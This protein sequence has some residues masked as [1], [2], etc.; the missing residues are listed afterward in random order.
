M[1]QMYRSGPGGYAT[2][3]DLEAYMRAGGMSGPVYGPAKRP[4]YNT[5]Q[6][7]NLRFRRRKRRRGRRGCVTPA[8]K[9]FN[10]FAWAGSA[11]TTSWTGQGHTGGE[12]LV[13][14]AQ[15]VTESTRVGRKVCVHDINIKGRVSMAAGTTVT[16][17]HNQVHLQLILDNQCN[18]ANATMADIY[19]TVASGIDSYRNLANQRRFRVL[20]K[21]SITLNAPLAGDGST[22]DHPTIIR[23]FAM[24][25]SCEIPI[26]Y[27]AT[28]GVVGE[29]QSSNIFLIAV[30]HQT[31][32]A[33]TLNARG[34]VRFVDT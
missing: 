12:S 18:G 22:Q 25:K 33:C 19:E 26:V 21:K 14:I 15:G 11:I 32:A 24:H 28:T 5:L 23:S 9:K 7:R 8:E 4:R 2:M 34:R 27:D 6:R 13:I 10:D 31:T 17:G 3:A 29:I 30:A 20:W 16:G 1:A